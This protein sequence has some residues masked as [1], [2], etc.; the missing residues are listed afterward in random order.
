MNRVSTNGHGARQQRDE[1]GGQRGRVGQRRKIYYDHWEDGLDTGLN[2][3]FPTFP[4][5]Q[6]T[7][8]LVLG[9]SSS[10]NGRVRDYSMTR[11][12]SVQ[13]HGA[14]RRA[15]P[16]VAMVFQLRP[17][18][19]GR[20]RGPNPAPPSVAQLLLGS[21]ESYA[22]PR[23]ASTAAMAGHRQRPVSLITTGPATVDHRR[24]GRCSRQ[25]HAGATSY[26]IRPAK[27]CIWATTR[28]PRSSNATSTWWRSRTTLIAI[29]SPGGTGGTV[30]FTLNRGRHYTNRNCGRD[31]RERP[32][33]RRHA[34]AVPAHQRRHEDLDHQAA[35]RHDP[36]RRRN[37]L[38]RHLPDPARPAPA[39]TT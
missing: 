29:V 21:S 32:D 22:G 13:R 1:L 38:D 31:L 16:G 3:T 20:V 10:A 12:C 18:N 37:L 14:R 11:A 4:N 33:R 26:S 27:T 39:T 28:S 25:A 15:V 23:C 35:C 5:P 2:S 36:Q 24:R 7:S 6:Q 34:G 8:T 9:G 17:G 19:R 30:S